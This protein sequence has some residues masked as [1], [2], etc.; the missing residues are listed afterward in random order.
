MAN[1][2]FWLGILA[3]TLVFG[4]T[5]VGCSEEEDGYYTFTEEDDKESKGYTFTFEVQN[6]NLFGQVGYGGGKIVKLEFLNGDNPQAPVIQTEEVDLSSEQSATFKVSGFTE[7]GYWDDKRLY[8]I[9]IFYAD[10]TRGGGT[11]S[12]RNNAKILAR[13]QDNAI[14]FFE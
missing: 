5:V 10:G 9:R 7:K 1:K 2:K 8:A 4:M 12:S 6:Y 13:C 11:D 14:I 3:L